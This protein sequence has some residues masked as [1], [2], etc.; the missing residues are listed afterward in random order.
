MV[1]RMG[2]CVILYV[3]IFMYVPMEKYWKVSGVRYGIFVRR[4]LC[5]PP[6]ALQQPSFC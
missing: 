1:V 4:Y 5:V 6:V 2:S 3:N